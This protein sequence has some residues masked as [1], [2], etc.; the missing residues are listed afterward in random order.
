MESESSWDSASSS[1][2]V[3]LLMCLVPRGLLG[4]VLF[5]GLSFLLCWVVTIIFFPFVKGLQWGLLVFCSCLIPLPQLFMY[6]FIFGSI[7]YSPCWPPSHHIAKDGLEPVIF[8][9]P[10]PKYCDYNYTH[11]YSVLEIKQLRCI[12]A[13]VCSFGQ[14]LTACISTGWPQ[15]LCPPVSSSF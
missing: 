6:L 10:F 11:L 9:F 2:S 12:S 1:F 7:S 13:V 4:A 5:L 8:P 3:L 14:G 15:A